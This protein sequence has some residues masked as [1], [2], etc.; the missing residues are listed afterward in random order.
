MQEV[1]RS[2]T[3]IVFKKKKQF[4]FL[5]GKKFKIFSKSFFSETMKERL[6]HTYAGKKTF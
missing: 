6:L 1:V 2:Q 5:V 4:F 3:M